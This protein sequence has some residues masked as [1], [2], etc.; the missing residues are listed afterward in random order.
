[1][2]DDQRRELG[3]GAVRCVHQPGEHGQIVGRV[4]DR[5][6]V[7]AQELGRGLDRVGDQSAHDRPDWVQ[8]V[9]E[10][11]RDAEVPAAAPKRPEEIS[12]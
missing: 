12:V 6:A 3:A 8:P 4:R 10:R 7:E 9:R 11:R 1:M 5:V 2:E